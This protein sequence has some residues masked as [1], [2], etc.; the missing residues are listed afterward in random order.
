MKLDD[1]MKL[2]YPIKITVEDFGYAVHIVDLPGCVST[3]ATKEEAL[4]L[5]NDKKRRWLIQAL[6]DGKRIKQPSR[7]K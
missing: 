1:Y 5:V 4:A 3:G 2:D 7:R 6:L